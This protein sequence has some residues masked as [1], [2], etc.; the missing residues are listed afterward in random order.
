MP[1][2]KPQAPKPSAGHGVD[3]ES[4]QSELR[5]SPRFWHILHLR[6]IRFAFVAVA[7]LDSRKKALTGTALKER[8]PPN[9]D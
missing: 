6:L 1:G 8:T 2:P 3:L 7:S 4:S 5:P 9:R